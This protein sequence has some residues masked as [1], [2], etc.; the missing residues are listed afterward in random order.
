LKLGK[1]GLILFIGGMSVLLFSTFFLGMLVG[2]HLDAYPERYSG[3]LVDIVRGRFSG[4]ALAPQKQETPSVGEQGVESGQATGEEDF[5]LTFYKTLGDNKSSSGIAENQATA[6]GLNR[7]KNTASEAK[8]HSLSGEAAA[9][10]ISGKV[11][12]GNNAPVSPVA[13]GKEVDKPIPPG[14]KKAPAASATTEAL[15]L[16]VAPSADKTQKKGGFQVQV[17]A[18]R[19]VLQAEKMDKRLKLLGF[20]TMIVPKEI[21][22]KGKWFRVIAVG[23]EDRPKAE[24]AAARI[25]QKIKG[26]K[27]II[28]PS[29]NGG[30]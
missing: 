5:D 29:K 6:D 15:P 12:P 8:N 17:A 26:V 22:D 7:E 27:C 10:V 16:P 14:Q 2:K 28:R 18:Y 4:L 1:L 9:G 23:F 30:A 13:A 20:A 21:P 11:A 24:S 25:T 3:G 19:D